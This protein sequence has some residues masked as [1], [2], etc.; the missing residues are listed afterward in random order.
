MHNGRH[1]G[2][3]VFFDDLDSRGK[4]ILLGT[5]KGFRF[6]G[7]MYLPQHQLHHPLFVNGMSLVRELRLV[8]GPRLH[9]L[10]QMV[11]AMETVPARM[12]THLMAK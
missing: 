9:L 5:K 10:I 7:L 6:S 3:F 12:K 8:K 4:F 2:G 1:R 11:H